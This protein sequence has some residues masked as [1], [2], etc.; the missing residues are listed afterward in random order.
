MGFFKRGFCHLASMGV[1]GGWKRGLE[2]AWEGLGR[3][4]G[5]VG[6]GLGSVLGRAWGRV[7]EGLA[8]YTSKAPFAKPGNVPKRH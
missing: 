5:R 1:R 4:W 6:E 7:G 8:F 2:R 3:G